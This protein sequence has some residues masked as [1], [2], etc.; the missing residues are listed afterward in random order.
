VTDAFENV[1]RR[2]LKS[3]GYPDVPLLVTPDP[4]IYLGEPEIHERIDGLL[5]KIVASF[6]TWPA[7][8]TRV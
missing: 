5:D 7:R 2:L 6:S 3:L 4:V 1:A 8:G